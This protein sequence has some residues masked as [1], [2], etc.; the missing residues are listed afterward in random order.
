MTHQPG[1]YRL[2]KS[3]ANSL[4]S[5]RMTRLSQDQGVDTKKPAQLTERNSEW[6]SSGARRFI[7]CMCTSSSNSSTS[8]T[9]HADRPAQKSRNHGFPLTTDAI[10]GPTDGKKLVPERDNSTPVSPPSS[11]DWQS[12]DFGDVV[13][14]L[15]DIENKYERRQPYKSIFIDAPLYQDYSQRVARKESRREARR[16]H[17][18]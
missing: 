12:K 6:N 10:S 8:K 15:K 16:R 2:P 18:K 14:R 17:G 1:S 4:Y 3:D 9:R 7:C 11:S 13:L 5:R